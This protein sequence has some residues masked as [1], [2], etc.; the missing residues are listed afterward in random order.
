[1][2]W[3]KRII[4]HIPNLKEIAG[5]YFENYISSMKQSTEVNLASGSLDS[6]C[7][8]QAIVIF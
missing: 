1:M 5:T 6:I 3:C 7:I 8:E 2:I 4:L